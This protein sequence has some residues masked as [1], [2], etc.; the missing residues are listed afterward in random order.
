MG[1][2]FLLGTMARPTKYTTERVA[3]IVEALQ[4]GNTRAAA[5]AFGGVDQ[6]TFDRWML[7]YAHFAEAVREAEA[8]AELAHV[9]TIK[10]ASDSGDWRAALAW[11]ERRRN[12]DWGKRE[13][14]EIIESVRE[15]A[16]S[17][18]WDHDEEAAAIAEVERL[19]RE[20]SGAGR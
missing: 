8:Q 4:G 16:R 19:M 13:K 17:E 9:A 15:M 18:G 12:R 2:A 10:H 5:S 7:R 3:K 14:L 20:Q 1:R 6:A 11:L